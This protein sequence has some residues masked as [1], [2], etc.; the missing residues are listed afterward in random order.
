MANAVV[1]VMRRVLDKPGGRTPRTVDELRPYIYRSVA[2][3]GAK[4][5]RTTSRRDRREALTARLNRPSSGH[6][7]PPTSHDDH[8]TAAMAVA[9]GRLSARQRAVIHLTYWEDLTPAD[10]ARR[11]GISDGS[12][13]RHLARARQ[14]LRTMLDV[15]FNLGDSDES[16]TETALGGAP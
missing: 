15:D 13:R 7:A 2:N 8:V 9:L 4:E 12:V 11:L 10:V 14:S 1:S 5:W 16:E 3:A 6:E